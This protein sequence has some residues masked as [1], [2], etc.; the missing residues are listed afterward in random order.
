MQAALNARLRMTTRLTFFDDE[1]GDEEMQLEP[2]DF[3]LIA[4]LVDRRG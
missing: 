1:R 3:N 2:D 4:G